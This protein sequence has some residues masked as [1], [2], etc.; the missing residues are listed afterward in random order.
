M[1]STQASTPLATRINHFFQHRT[2]RQRIVFEKVRQTLSLPTV[3]RRRA[4]A[5]ELSVARPFAIDRERGFNVFPPGAFP[6]AQEIVAE[7]QNL[8]RDVDLT[9]PGLS[10]K[11]RSGFMST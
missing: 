2:E 10:K 8:G 5:R 6:E 4:A 9:R 11:A 1:S 7:T 3:L